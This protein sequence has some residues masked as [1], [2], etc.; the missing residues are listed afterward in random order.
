MKINLGVFFGG[1]SVE[2]EIAV[3]SALQAIHALDKE[4][5]EVIPIYLSKDGQLYT[6]DSLLDIEN[7]K[8]SGKLLAACLKI[9]LVR[10]D[11]E[12]CG[13][14]IPPKMFGNNLLFKLDVV[15]PIVHGTNCEDGTVQGYLELLN[16]PYVGANVLASALGM[17][18]IATK[19]I[20][21]CNGVP[22][23]DSLSYSVREWYKEGETIVGEIEEKIG[24]PVIVKPVNLGSSV[25][26]NKATDQEQLENAMDLAFSFAPRVLVEKAI[27]NLKEVNCSVL[28]D[29]DNPQPSVCEEPLGSDEILSYND[30]YLSKSA[31]KGMS[32]TKRKL[33]ADIPAEMD[34]EVKDLAVKV[35]KVLGCHG[36]VRIDFLIDQDTGTVY[37]NE[38]NTIP[39]SLSFYLWEATGKPFGQLLDDLIS[40]AL[41]RD[42]EKQKI[43]Y[44]YDVNIFSLQ[45]KG[46]K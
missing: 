31:S 18:K 37:V 24:Y 13:F 40:L 28:G 34:S 14:R 4:K 42:R 26:I 21:K 9:A 3:I 6:G 12:V 16:I 36:V 19:N 25:G 17:D 33:P 43:T 15:L 22:V 35:F 7:Y 27:T 11:N 46:A 5:Y 10:N 38:I 29:Y 39:G 23:L 20:L 8:D 32:S 30:K 45:G 1:S 41:Q 2:H 44:T